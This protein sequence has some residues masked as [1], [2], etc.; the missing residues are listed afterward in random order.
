LAAAVP[1]G[2]GNVVALAFSPPD[3]RRLA[4]SYLD[5]GFR[6]WDLQTFAEEAE[7]RLNEPGGGVAFSPDGKLLACA[8][9]RGQV[10]LR[11]L[12]TTGAHPTV[13]EHGSLA[14]SLTFSPDGRLLASGGEDHAVKLW[15]VAQGKHARTLRGH[16][17]R[18]QGVAFSPD[19]RQVVSASSDC[20][21][22]LWDV[23]GEDD[24][25]LRAAPSRVHAAAFFPDGRRFAS[26]EAWGAIRVWDTL[27]GEEERT[28]Y[29]RDIPGRPGLRDH[30]LGH[31]D[32]SG[33]PEAARAHGRSV[34][35]GRQPGRDADRL[36]R[37]G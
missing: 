33:A 26:L 14:K 17:Q 31:G 13:F 28:L 10:Y 21:V 4:A 20:T 34:G 7:F 3:G 24:L 2:R 32:R 1:G 11:D 27:T 5:T 35:R 23:E 18:V 29:H 9:K 22:K 15:S 6:V 36:V 19:G 8:S 16:E 25:V 37:L 30:A 12:E